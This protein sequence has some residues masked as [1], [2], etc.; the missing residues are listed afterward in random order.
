MQG[1]IVVGAGVETSWDRTKVEQMCEDRAP[2]TML[3]SEGATVHRGL[4]CREHTTRE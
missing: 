2:V 3:D 1:C 4:Q